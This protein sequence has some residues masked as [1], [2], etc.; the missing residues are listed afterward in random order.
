MPCVN[1]TNDGPT[2]ASIGNTTTYSRGFPSTTF[3]TSTTTAVSGPLSNSTSS[4]YGASS[5]QVLPT[6][7]TS[8]PPPLPDLDH[9]HPP[10][11]SR[12]DVRPRDATLDV[13]SSDVAASQDN[14]IP[15]KAWSGLRNYLHHHLS[16]TFEGEKTGDDLES[17]GSI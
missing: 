13:E 12:P 17:E 9:H 15:N 3:Q 10:P 8:L 6:T 2:N 1:L 7:A 5:R 11:P 4:G 16:P 14:S